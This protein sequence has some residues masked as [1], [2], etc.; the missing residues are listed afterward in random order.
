MLHSKYVI[1][2][3]IIHF[4]VIFPFTEFIYIPLLQDIDF[5]SFKMPINDKVSKPIELIEKTS[6]HFK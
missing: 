4:V 2:I 6:K 1:L 3:K 5:F